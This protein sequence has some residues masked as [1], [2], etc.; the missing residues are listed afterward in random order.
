MN[1]SFNRLVAFLLIA[2]FSTFTGCKKEDALTIPPEQIHFV[3]TAAEYY[4]TNNP[5]TV[6]KVPVGLTTPST[7]PVTVNY[8]VSSSTGAT[9]GQQ[10]TLTGSSITIPA[11]KS[12]DSIPIKGIFSGYPTGRKDTLTLTI[13]GGG[14]DVADFNKVFKLVLQKYCNVVVADLLG[15]YANSFDLQTGQPT[16]GPYGTS[17]SN[18]VTI[19]PTKSTVKISNFWDV[20][21]SITVELDYADP[22]NFKATIP[23]QSLYNDPTY[24]KATISQ[25]GNGS[26]SSCD[27]TFTFSYTVTV[28]AGS[29]GNFTTKIG[30]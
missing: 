1:K 4:I 15:D 2:S 21:T 27:N 6:F 8:T 25:V 23:T 29:F 20:G 22:A 28:A 12:I 17:I 9:P 7:S 5:N 18:P 13:T 26:F 16:Y 10:Y 14:K 30:R 3:G 24:G 19:S 11:G